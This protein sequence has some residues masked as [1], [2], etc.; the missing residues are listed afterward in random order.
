MWQDFDP[1]RSSNDNFNDNDNVNLMVDPPHDDLLVKELNELSVVEREK[2]FEDVHGVAPI[3]EETPYLIASRLK[4]LQQELV[5]IPKSQRRALDRALFLRPSLEY[6]KKFRLMFLRAVSYDAQEAARRMC[7]HF[8]DKLELFG[9]EKLAKR[10]TLD[11]MDADDM[12]A[13]STGSVLVLPEKDRAGRTVLFTNMKLCRYKR[14]KNQVR[15]GTGNRMMSPSPCPCAIFLCRCS[16][17]SC[18]S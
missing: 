18:F 4:E 11:D 6:D 13:G 10:I 16:H 1:G 9:E 3:Q 8:Q 17:P 15:D 2:V 14:S 12:E 7:K 5:K